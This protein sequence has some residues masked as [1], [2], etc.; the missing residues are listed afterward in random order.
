MDKKFELLIRKIKY[1][2]TKRP[3]KIIKHHKLKGGN[4]IHLKLGYRTALNDICWEIEKGG[5]TD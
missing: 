4:A 1:S 3:N 2:L 5:H